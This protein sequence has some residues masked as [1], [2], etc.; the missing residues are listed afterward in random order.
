MWD[1]E[2][3]DAKDIVVALQRACD[4]V[5]HISQSLVA[6]AKLDAAQKR[7]SPDGIWCLFDPR[8]KNQVV[9]NTYDVG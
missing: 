1:Q 9:V 2:G 8:C 5:S 3:G 6:K 4:L 7:V